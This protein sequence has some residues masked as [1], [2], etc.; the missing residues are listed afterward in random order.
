MDLEEGRT[1]LQ[2]SFHGIPH[3]N[4]AVCLWLREDKTHLSYSPSAAEPETIS[5][6]SCVIICWRT[7]L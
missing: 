6:I 2:N 4:T 5:V 1:V 3:R 7:R